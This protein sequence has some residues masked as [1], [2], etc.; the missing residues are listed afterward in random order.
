MIQSDLEDSQRAA[1]D[2]V[3]GGGESGP[4]HRPMK[5]E[6]VQ[7]IADQCAAAGVPLFVKQDSGPRPGQQGRLPDSLWARKEMPEVK[8]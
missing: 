6:W 2:F 1:L 7:S 8:Q 4:G 3:I 5:V